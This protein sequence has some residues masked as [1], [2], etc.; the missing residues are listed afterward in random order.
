M[1]ETLGWSTQVLKVE[2]PRTEGGGAQ[3]LRWSS[4]GLK[5][6]EPRT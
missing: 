2:H 4:P 6:E 3:D 5:V 1:P